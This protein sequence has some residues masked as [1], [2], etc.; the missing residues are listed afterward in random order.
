[1]EK[2]RFSEEQM[3]GMLKQHEAGLQMADPCRE[4]GNSRSHSMSLQQQLRCCQL[5]RTV[6]SVALTLLGAVWSYCH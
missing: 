2:S 4:H 6:G 3:I 1:M 5:L